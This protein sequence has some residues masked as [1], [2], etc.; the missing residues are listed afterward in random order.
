MGRGSLQKE[1]EIFWIR[2]KTSVHPARLRENHCLSISEGHL[3]TNTILSVLHLQ[4][5]K[6]NIYKCVLFSLFS[7]TRLGDAKNV[8]LSRCRLLV[9]MT[10]GLKLSYYRG[11][12]KNLSIMSFKTYTT[13]LS[14]IDCMK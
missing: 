14:N 3:S 5:P 6:S 12:T 13:S 9:N 2:P 11:N 8:V 7:M 4:G 1:I 10:N